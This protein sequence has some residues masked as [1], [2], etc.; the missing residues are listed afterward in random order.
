MYREE[1][2]F[3]E[4]TYIVDKMVFDLIKILEMIEDVVLKD[5]VEFVLKAGEQSCLLKWVDTLVYPFRLPINVFQ[6]IY[7]EFFEDVHHPCNNL[8]LIKVSIASHRIFLRN[9]SFCKILIQRIRTVETFWSLNQRL[10]LESRRFHEMSNCGICHIS[11][12]Q[13]WF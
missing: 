11:S 2:L 7:A 6:I 10:G 13:N 3:S 9:H 4:A 12:L 1:T 5:S 8:W